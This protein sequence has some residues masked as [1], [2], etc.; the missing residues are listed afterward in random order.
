MIGRRLPSNTDEEPTLYRMRIFAPDEVSAKSRF[1]YF[2]KK[3]KKIKK[4][5][6]EIV[7]CGV[8]RSTW[9]ARDI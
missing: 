4:T 2:L 5:V 8:V 3:L 6:G 7:Y 9:C 1:W